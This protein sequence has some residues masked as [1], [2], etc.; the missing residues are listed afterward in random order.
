M[1]A[2]TPQ[3]QVPLR[4]VRFDIMVAGA[5]QDVA[6]AHQDLLMQLG[7]CPAAQPYGPLGAVAR[8]GYGQ[9]LGPWEMVVLEE[10]PAA[11]TVRALSVV[12]PLKMKGWLSQWTQ[13][14]PNVVLAVLG[15]VQREGQGFIAGRKVAFVAVALPEHPF[16]LHDTLTVS[17]AK[18]LGPAQPSWGVTRNSDEAK[19]WMF[20]KMLRPLI[21]TDV[22]HAWCNARALD[23]TLELPSA[24]GPLLPARRF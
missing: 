3:E 15:R 5:A 20:E 19:G 8:L 4:T 18:R 1:T 14:H 23:Q 2:P 10:D 17:Q 9:I 24:S 22:M 21:D 7:S 6:A 13:H 16:I 12:V 11:T